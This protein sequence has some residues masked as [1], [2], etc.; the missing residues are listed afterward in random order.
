M[1]SSAFIEFNNDRIRPKVLLA[2]RRHFRQGHSQIKAL[3]S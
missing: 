3:K 2:Y 1:V